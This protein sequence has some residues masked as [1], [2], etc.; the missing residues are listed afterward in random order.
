M[1]F[2]HQRFGDASKA[3]AS[4]DVALA[5]RTAANGVHKARDGRFAYLHQG[6]PESTGKLMRGLACEDMTEIVNGAMPARDA[7][8]WQRRAAAAPLTGVRA[9][10]LI[11][12]PAGPAC[13]CTPAH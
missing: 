9:P 2:A 7:I 12:P 5:S 13:A 10:D 4:P 8:D 6:F 1:S 11:R 3:R